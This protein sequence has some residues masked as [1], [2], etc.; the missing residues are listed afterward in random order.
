MRLPRTAA[1]WLL[2]LL[3]VLLT[4]S[5]VIVDHSEYAPL[6]TL[7][8]GHDLAW[9]ATVFRALLLFHG[10]A[11][12]AAVFFREK[13]AA[14]ASGTKNDGASGY[15]VSSREI[16]FLLILAFVALI[17]RIPNLDS[18]LWVDE[19]FTLVDF[20]RAPWGEIVTSFPSQNQHLLY[21]I[22]ARASFDIFGETAWALRL[23]ALLFGVLSIVGTYLLARKL[24]GRTTAMLASGLMAVSYH[25]VWFSQNARGYTGLLL[26]SIL[27]TWLYFEAFDRR[28]W[29]WWMLYSASIILGMW[30]HMTMAFVGLAHGLSYLFFLAFP[31]AGRDEWA[32]SGSPERYSGLMPI[33]AWALSVTVTAQLYA[34]ALP[35]FLREG[36]HEESKDALWTNPVWV[37]TESLQNLSIGFAGI[38]VVLLGG[39]F[40]AFG[41]FCLYKKNKRAAIVMALPPVFAGT[42]ML[43]LGHNLFP[44]FF[45]FAVGFA[46][47]IV[48]QGALALPAFLGS[49]I[50]P[51][52]E[53]G[54]LLRIAGIGFGL[55]M[56]AASLITVPRNYFLPKQDFSGA[57]EFVESARGPNDTVIGASIAGTMYERYYAPDW[58]TA[59]NKQELE[60]LEG[61]GGVWLVYTLSPEIVAFHP[62]M[63]KKINT[64]YDVVKTFPGTLNGGE[65][66]VCRKREE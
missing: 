58:K 15:C 2:L 14:L 32:E 46:L 25:H 54:S 8:E 12:A 16:W 57:R 42:L 26:F 13:F 28:N 29:T 44:R 5:A 24:L 7:E 55:L 1:A 22:L 18:D 45:F 30:V 41:W 10:L 51:L 19:V 50:K 21:S 6:L 53:K 66:Y 39:A 11:L 43:S 48:I 40:L 49:F 3:A 47:I 62:E 23:P 56:V 60:S 33:A 65:I 17:L 36:L 63:W 4:V 64:E 59:E 9:G 61:E 52:K 37:I 38:A 35:E 27:A 20:V 34:L 31:S